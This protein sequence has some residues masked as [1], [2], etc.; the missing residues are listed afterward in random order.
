MI[1][2][3]PVYLAR[4]RASFTAALTSIYNLYVIVIS[5]GVILAAAYIY[6]REGLNIFVV[7][8]LPS[9][10]IFVVL[11]FRAILSRELA[12]SNQGLHFRQKG[13]DAL[14][15]WEE[16]ER[17]KIDDWR[18]RLFVTVKGR[19][20]ELYVHG[21]EKEPYREVMRVLKMETA[22]RGLEVVKE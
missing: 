14:Y 16:I 13:V 6:L 20:R 15:R 4:A 19:E 8:V 10:T 11:Y 5:V 9:M 12:V 7:I 21:L 17:I 22:V 1:D 3:K 2:S 18:K